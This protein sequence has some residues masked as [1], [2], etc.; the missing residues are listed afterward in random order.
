[1]PERRSSLTPAYSW[2]AGSQRYRNVAKGRWV[3]RQQVRQ[4][5]DIALDRS[6]NEVARLSRE[7]VAGRINL[8]DWQTSVAR[9]VKSMHM[10]SAALAK[11]GWAQMTPQDTGRAGRII[12]DEYAYL[13]NFAQQVKTGQQKLDGSLV[14]RANLYAQAPRGTYHAIEQRGMMEQG[15]TECRNVLGPADHCEGANSCIEQTA[16]GWVS[17]SGGAMVPIG[18]RLCLANCRCRLEYR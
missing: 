18:R 5:L 14:T 16:K 15:K 7:L 4:A 12:R 10:A 1:M 9:E 8:A 2:H 6:R 17:L 11:G 3:S 13:A